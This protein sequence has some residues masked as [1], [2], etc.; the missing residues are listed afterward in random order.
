[1]QY[2]FTGKQRTYN[3]NCKDLVLKSCYAF[4]GL[5]IAKVRNI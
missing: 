5:A 4:Y 1:M 3:G 2:R